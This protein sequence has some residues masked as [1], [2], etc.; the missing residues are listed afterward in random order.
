MSGVG[1][2]FV[3]CGGALVG[4][5]LALLLYALCYSG[6]T[7]DQVH[8]AYVQGR[9]DGWA[10]S[11]A[12]RMVALGQALEAAD[13]QEIAEGPAGNDV[14]Y[15]HGIPYRPSLQGRRCGWHAAMGQ[16]DEEVAG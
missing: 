4:G 14:R 9:Q 1:T 8:E 6:G 13:G 7:S 2:F 10:E 15:C 16:R 12:R 3:A 5:F 11:E